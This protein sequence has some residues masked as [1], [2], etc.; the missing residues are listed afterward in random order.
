MQL[1][2]FYLILLT[3]ISFIFKISK[4]VDCTK[5]I[6]GVSKYSIEETVNSWWD[7]RVC[8]DARQDIQNARDQAKEN[9]S[10]TCL[11]VD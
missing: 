1:E 3:L 6:N 8:L 2:A 11:K 7:N 4:H 9:I 10:I 5:H